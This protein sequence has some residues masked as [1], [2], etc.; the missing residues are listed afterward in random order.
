MTQKQN[1]AIICLSPNN[2]GMEIDAINLAEKLSDHSNITLIAKKNSFIEKRSTDYLKDK[3]INIETIKFTANLG[4][5]IIINARKIVKKNNIKN[6]IFFGASELK[7]LFFSF[8]GLNINL[9]VRHGTTKSTPKK[10]PFYKLIYSK[11]NWHVSISKH[12]QKNVAF[13][14]PFGSA[15]K[16]TII[17]PSISVNKIVKMSHSVANSRLVLSHTGRITEGKGQI[18]AIKACKILEDNDIDFVFY[19]IGSFEKNSKKDFL[20]FHS[21]LSYRDKIKLVGFTHNVNQYLSQSDIFIFP[22]YGEGLGNSFL[23]A[24]SMNIPCISYNNTVFPE[25]NEIGLHFHLVENKNIQALK[26]KLLYIANNLEDE[27]LKSNNNSSKME[28]VFSLDQEISKFLEI[29]V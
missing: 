28:L 21:S 18:D 19:I 11:V 7:S 4:P 24:L 17:S 26:S 15:T 13:I 27:K 29:L 8:L 10:N 9:I 23:E 12:I 1:T 14:I 25:I 16:S 22:S 20:Q 6:V 3:N 2:G 5:S